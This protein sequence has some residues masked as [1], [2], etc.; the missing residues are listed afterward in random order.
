MKSEKEIRN[1]IDE[2]KYV[3]FDKGS[4][5][6]YELRAEIEVLE[7]VLESGVEQ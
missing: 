6:E 3:I 1:K 7:W 2:L 4:I 5:D